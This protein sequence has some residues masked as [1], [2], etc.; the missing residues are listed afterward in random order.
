MSLTHLKGLPAGALKL[1]LNYTQTWVGVPICSNNHINTGSHC[2][3][4][5][6]GYDPVLDVTANR[7]ELALPN[8][9]GYSTNKT[10]PTSWSS[11]TRMVAARVATSDG[12]INDIRGDETGDGTSECDGEMGSK[13]DVHSG[14]GNV[15]TGGA[16]GG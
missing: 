8:L 7:S 12:T 16:G 1:G 5:V 14:E 2:L 3:S 6:S 13:P 10:N 11:S 4:R 9:S 15:Y